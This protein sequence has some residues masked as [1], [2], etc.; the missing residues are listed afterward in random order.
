M[1]KS[2]R[3]KQHIQKITTQTNLTEKTEQ[4]NPETRGAPI[5]SQLC[6]AERQSENYLCNLVIGKLL[7]T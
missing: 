2:R 7:V 4:K 3:N 1:L 6:V 5:Q